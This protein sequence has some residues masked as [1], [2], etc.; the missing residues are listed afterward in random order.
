MLYLKTEEIKESKVLP[1]QEPKNS[2]FKKEPVI[3]LTARSLK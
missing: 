2:W 3:S 1:A